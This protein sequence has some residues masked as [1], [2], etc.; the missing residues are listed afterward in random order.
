MVRSTLQH[1]Q[2]GKKNTDIVSTGKP[3]CQHSTKKS[4]PTWPNDF[5]DTSPVKR[6][7][8]MQNI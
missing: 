7:T 6:D 5:A 1:L 3:S 8:G 2:H 4:S